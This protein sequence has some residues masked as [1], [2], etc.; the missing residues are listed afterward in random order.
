MSLRLNAVVAGAAFRTA[1]LV[2][3]SPSSGGQL[4]DR[5]RLP[6]VTPSQTSERPKES[7]SP[8]SSRDGAVAVAPLFARDCVTLGA[9]RWG[10]EFRSR[11]AEADSGARP[12]VSMRAACAIRVASSAADAAIATERVE[13]D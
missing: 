6:W 9:M 2:V 3:G 5:S 13:N 7:T 4:E 1:Q 8:T 11:S 10:I 12:L